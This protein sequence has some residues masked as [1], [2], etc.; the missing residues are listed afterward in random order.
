MTE[1]DCIIVATAIAVVGVIII[2]AIGCDAHWQEARPA[3]LVTA[4]TSL[5]GR[6]SHHPHG[7]AGRCGP[8]HT[9]GHGDQDK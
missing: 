3:S 8:I 5:L 4:I 9:R 1:A 2:G 7:P 6:A